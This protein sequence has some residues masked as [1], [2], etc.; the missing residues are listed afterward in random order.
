MIVIGAITGDSVG[1]L[2]MAGM[3]PG[4]MLAMIFCIYIIIVSIRD[5]S[6]PKMDPVPWRERWRAT[7]RAFWGLLAP[8]IILGGIYS[9]VF[10]PT[11]AAAVGVTYGLFIS[12]FLYKTISWGRF[13]KILMESA[14]LSG[15]ILFIVAG[16]M[17]FGQVVILMEVPQ[18]ICNGLAALPIPPL[19]ILGLVLIFILILGALMDELSILL[20][21]YPILY[22][23][24]VQHFKFDS[25]WFALVFV[26]TLEVGLVAPPVGINVFVVQ[27]IDK[28]AKFEEVV[29]GVFPFMMLMIAAILLV[30][31]IKPLSLWLPSLLD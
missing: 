24:F 2:F 16:A 6:S 28:S 13:I 18:I 27:G 29:K 20:I 9:G 25:I 17:I 12:L 3:L 8:A 5:K 10:T 30:V 7:Y 26:F 23:I 1:K 15:M 11:E 31:F 14:K 22:Y 4:I 21:T 19:A